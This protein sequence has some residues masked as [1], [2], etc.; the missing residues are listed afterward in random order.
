ML[1]H[2]NLYYHLLIHVLNVDWLISLQ[3]AGENN[4]AAIKWCKISI[5]ACAIK[6]NMARFA[7]LISKLKLKVCFINTVVLQN[8]NLQQLHFQIL[9]VIV[10]IC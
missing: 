7:E 1:K 2:F 5:Y 3:I 8:H 6:V 4:T 9:Y 10:H